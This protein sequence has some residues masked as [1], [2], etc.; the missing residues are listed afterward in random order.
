M[1]NERHSS[2]N[3][4]RKTAAFNR[5]VGRRFRIAR[6]TAGKL[7]GQK[8]A[9]ALGMPMTCY[10]NIENG[11]ETVFA[12][13]LVR[14]SSLLSVSTDFLLGVSSDPSLDNTEPGFR[15]WLISAAAR[16]AAD[17]AELAEKYA[18]IEA[19][20]D[21]I[22]TLLVDLI[23]TAEDLTAA[24]ERVQKLNPNDFQDLR[25]GA[26]LVAAAEEC[27][28]AVARTRNAIP[29]AIEGETPCP[30]SI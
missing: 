24:L 7:S 12:K 21:A 29:N 11:R 20:S 3:S 2:R 8:M 1:A 28:L 14:A 16:Q 4:R 22:E 15:E 9:D 26:P 27:R 23:G 5:Q 30:L 6:M 17:R 19:R 18:A 25:A 10:M 13:T